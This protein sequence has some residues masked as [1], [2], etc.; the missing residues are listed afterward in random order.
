V[1]AGGC[2][3]RGALVLA[4]LVGGAR[5]AWAHRLQLELFRE[6]G[7]RLRCELFFSDGAT[8]EGAELVLLRLEGD[9]ERELARAES[10]AEGV[11]CF[12]V[13]AP[14]RY[15]VEARDASLHRA[16]RELEVAPDEASS[17]TAAVSSEPPAARSERGERPWGGV[18]G[19][20]LVI[21]LLAGG[22]RLWQA[23]RR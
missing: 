8:P 5:P 3:V 18:L 19:G 4:V 21:A 22:L 20:L 23:R 17:S 1:S 14:G 6:E 16:S 11:A 12:T 15:R 10:D 13:P 9:V 7:G 2:V